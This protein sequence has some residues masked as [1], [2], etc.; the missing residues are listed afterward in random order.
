MAT[1]S[2]QH[3]F[4]FKAVDAISGENLEGTFVFNKILSYGQQLRFDTLYRKYLGEGDPKFA[5]PEARLR[6]TVLAEINSSLVS[7]PKFWV[8]SFD[9]LNLLDD[10]I[11][12]EIW[13]KIREVQNEATAARAEKDEAAAAALKAKIEKDAFE[14]DQTRAKEG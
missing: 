10:N 4:A 9:G 6:A 12:T 11:A 1:F 14:I 8:N 7:A 3:Q 13:T 5:S 2:N